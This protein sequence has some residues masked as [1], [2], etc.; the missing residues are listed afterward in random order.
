MRRFF[1]LLEKCIYLNTAYTA[2][3]AQPLLEWRHADERSYFEGGDKYKLDNEKRYAALAKEKMATFL[4]ASA[5][6]TFI[7]SN[8]STAFHHALTLLPRD[9]H[10]LVLE[11]EYPSLLGTIH[12]HGFSTTVL[13]IGET[14]EEE[15]ARVLNTK[16]IDVLALSMVQY[17]SGI[18]FDEKELKKIKANHP[19]LI[20]MVDMTQCVGGH[21]FSF[22]DS[23]IDAIFGSTYKWLMA[24]H[25]TGFAAFQPSFIHRT[26]CSIEA[27]TNMYDRGQ[28][29]VS[30]LGSLSFMLTL[31]SQQ[32]FSAL[33][34]HKSKLSQALR[35][36]L[37][38][39]G[40]LDKRV[41]ERPQH[42]SIY[43]FRAHDRVFEK[44]KAHEIRCIQRGQGIRVAVHHYNNEAD[45]AVFF[46]TLDALL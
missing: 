23:P 21:F 20:I 36:G 32:D 17:I 38:Q 6:Y 24:G 9:F 1:P 35:L 15:V 40:L 5:P 16:K 19:N 7:T 28:C 34:E 26:Q 2:P 3:L 41:V 45:L 11:E 46:S 14:M 31:I 39:R 10:F 4:N 8:F 30:A 27:I 44:L 12:S 18:R 29:S 13:P 37:H 43:T 25:G 42:S 22:D 33:M